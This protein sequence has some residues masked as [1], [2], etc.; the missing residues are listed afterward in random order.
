MGDT[1]AASGGDAALVRVHGTRKALAISVDTTPR[2]CLA[3]PV[4]GGMQAVAETWRNITATGATPLAI[5]NCLNFGNPERPEIMGQFVGCLEGMR[6]ACAALDYPVVSGNVSLYNETDGVGIPPTPA[7]GG[8]GLIKD[9]TK[10]ATLAF[11]EAGDM[12]F[13]V[14]ETHGHLDCTIFAEVFGTGTGA[15]PPVDLA[16]ERRH[17]DF[18]RAQILNGTLTAAH[19][20]SDGGLL[21]A[22][23]EMSLASG[24]GCRLHDASHAFWF[25]EDQARYVI[26][27]PPAAADTFQTAAQQASVPTTPLGETTAT[28]D[29]TIGD[30]AR[31]S[32]ETLERAHEDWLPDYMEAETHGDDA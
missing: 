6:A 12:I 18:I 17:G 24:L 20:V 3:D 1:L 13:V 16:A 10:A 22:L 5:T 9:S 29:L 21:I 7:I 26:T 19:D 25:G 4:S 32:L 14:G 2:Y 27:L 31:I 8:V 15:P 30:T 28:A 11:K 23:A